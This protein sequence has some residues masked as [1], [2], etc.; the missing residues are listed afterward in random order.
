MRD[1]DVSKRH[2]HQ[3]KML[4]QNSG[5]AALSNNLREVLSN[6]SDYWL[7]CSSISSYQF[8]ENKID[9]KLRLN[10]QETTTSGDS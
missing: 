10:K 7:M 4:D 6:K 5:A 3:L 2:A 1:V 9:V 8:G